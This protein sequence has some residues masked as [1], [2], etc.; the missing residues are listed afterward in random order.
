[1]ANFGLSVRRKVDGDCRRQRAHLPRH[2]SRLFPCSLSL[3]ILRTHAFRLPTIADAHAYVTTLY[4]RF[5]AKAY[6]TNRTIVPIPDAPAKIS[7]T[8]SMACLCKASVSGKRLVRRV[9]P[10]RKEPGG[11]LG[12]LRPLWR[13][14]PP[15]SWPSENHAAFR[16]TQSAGI[17]SLRNNISSPFWVRRAATKSGDARAVQDGRCE[18]TGDGEA[19]YAIALLPPMGLH[20][21]PSKILTGPGTDA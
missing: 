8:P 18:N 1:M 21:S 12:F 20:E 13:S 6:H 3:L 19:H 15:T 4:R 14:D 10:L 5:C 7:R 9:V 17:G 16:D 11:Y 2:R